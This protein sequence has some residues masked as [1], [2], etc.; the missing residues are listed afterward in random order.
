MIIEITS[1]GNTVYVEVEASTEESATT[2]AVA[3]TS[4]HYAHRETYRTDAPSTYLA[5]FD[6]H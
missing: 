6:I 5:T 3:A 1:A 2:Q 4:G